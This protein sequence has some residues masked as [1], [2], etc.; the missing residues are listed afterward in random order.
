MGVVIS[1]VR[2]RTIWTLLAA[3]VG[4]FLGYILSI[5]FLSTTRSIP[6]A[7][8]FTLG[9]GV[10]FAVIGGQRTRG[11]P[12]PCLKVLQP[13]LGA[14]GGLLFALLGFYVMYRVY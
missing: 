7:A 3:P 13:I 5:I 10:L 14:L 4:S 1:V 9:G 6:L 8:I 2:K 12:L 11:K